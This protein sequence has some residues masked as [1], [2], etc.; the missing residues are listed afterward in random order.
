MEKKQLSEL[1]ATRLLR[2]FPQLQIVTLIQ[3]YEEHQEI[4]GSTRYDDPD[5]Q[6]REL[7]NVVAS[8]VSAV[9]GGRK[10]PALCWTKLQPIIL[11]MKQIEAHCKFIGC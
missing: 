9:E 1:S 4:L 11:R 2:H 8:A 7:W 6:V 10:T 5:P 3:K